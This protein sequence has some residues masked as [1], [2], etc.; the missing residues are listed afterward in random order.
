MPNI[1]KIGGI[2]IA[3]LV[4][5]VIFFTHT[6]DVDYQ[7]N[8]FRNKNPHGGAI[9]G[10]V[11]LRI[12]FLGASVTRGEV[13]TGDRGY[14]KHIRDK[15]TSLGNPVN[16]VGFNR[17]GDF[18]DNDVEGYGA[19][20]IRQIRDH[21]G[22]AVSYLQ[23]NLVLIQVGT[24]DCFQKD[25]PTNI[26]ARMRD[27][28]DYLLEASPRVT[29]ILSTLATTPDPEVEPCMKSANAQIRQVATDLIRE[30]KPVTLAEMH[31]D[32]GLPYRPRPEDI[33]GDRIHPTDEGYIMMG[34]IFLEKIREAEEKG[35]LRHPANNGIPFDGEESREVEDQLHEKA[36][37]EH[38]L[39]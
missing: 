27:L 10:G 17:F 14:R 25:D 12:M 11:P 1:Y 38:P 6:V 36:D 37:K 4:L 18:P 26:L 9:A 20:R 28:V 34:D 32:Q 31:Y 16:C 35:F 2:S 5:I 8:K 19:N 39:K 21:A 33:G 15:L 13:S 24:S 29:V 23:P 22:Q 3:A 30:K 7:W